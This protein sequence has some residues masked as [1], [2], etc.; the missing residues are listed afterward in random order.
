MGIGRAKL[1][2]QD[3]QLKSSPAEENGEAMKMEICFWIGSDRQVGIVIYGSDSGT[4]D[5]EGRPVPIM[6]YR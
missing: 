5:E 2:V 1:L 6:V 3:E 4:N